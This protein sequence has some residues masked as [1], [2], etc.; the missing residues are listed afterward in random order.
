M[1]NQ[2][3]HVLALAAI[4]AGC[5]NLGAYNPEFVDSDDLA[6]ADVDADADADSDSDSDSDSD[7]DTDDCDPPELWDLGAVGP[8][9]GN[10]SPTYVGVSLW[11][12][13]ENG[14]I[15]DYGID[16][17]DA[18]A[19]LVFDLFDGN[20]GL[21]CSA[22][23]DASTSWSPSNANWITD[24]GGTVWEGYSFSLNGND[25]FTDC[26]NLDGTLGYADVRL[27]AASR[28]WRIGIGGMT[29]SMRADLQSAVDGA[30][31][32]GTWASEWDPYVLSQ[33]VDFGGAN[34]LE[35]TYTM[36]FP[37]TCYDMTTN[38]TGSLTPNNAANSG[39]VNGYL[40]SSGAWTIVNMGQLP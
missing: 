9:A 31:G 40:G 33:Y 35:T 2:H 25:G 22:I 11:G 4:I 8:I 26:G 20:G 16:G 3:L 6:D 28:T 1:K 30:L 36:A 12:I 15:Y 18:S 37:H 7:A 39:P 24:T 5:G 19:Y 29:S 34:A 17:V 14:A 32:A 27:W 10:M 38:G 23:F 13:L 21:L